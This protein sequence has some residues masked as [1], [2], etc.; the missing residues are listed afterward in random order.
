[1]YICNY[2]IYSH[3]IAMAAKIKFNLGAALLLAS[4]VSFVFARRLLLYLA[5]LARFP[6]LCF[7][8]CFILMDPGSFMGTL[9]YFALFSLD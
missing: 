5:N 8:C 9:P 6:S 1:M 4:A 7:A 3:H 2:F